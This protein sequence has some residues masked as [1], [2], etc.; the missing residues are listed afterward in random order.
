M[1]GLIGVSLYGTVGLTRSSP[2]QIQFVILGNDRPARPDE[3][4]QWTVA[5]IAPPEAP[6]Y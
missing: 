2:S 3:M 4:V 6:T 1:M 5:S